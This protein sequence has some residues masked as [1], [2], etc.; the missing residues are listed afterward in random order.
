MYQ[1]IC[2]L[3][4]NFRKPMVAHRQL[5]TQPNRLLIRPSNEDAWFIMRAIPSLAQTQIVTDCHNG[6]FTG[7]TPDGVV[8][9]LKLQGWEEILELRCIKYAQI[10]GGEDIFKCNE[11]NII[12]RH[13][14]SGRLNEWTLEEMDH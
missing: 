13:L 3:I 10:Q 11:R 5:Y 8:M 12:R 6:Y 4:E 1:F 14:L 9:T 7:K 2:K